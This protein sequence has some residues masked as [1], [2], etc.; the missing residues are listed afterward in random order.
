MSITHLV[1]THALAE[2]LDDPNWIVFDC[3]FLLT[4][5]D[6]R[7]A[8]YLQ[9]HIPGAVYAHLDRDLSAPIVPGVTGRH[10]LPAPEKAARRFGELG[11]GPGMQVV[12]YDDLGGSL[13]AVRLWW[14]LRWLGHTAV[15]VLDGG[16]QGWLAEGRPV[17]NGTETRPAQPFAARPQPGMLLTSDEVEQIRRDPAYRLVDVRLPERYRG[18]VEP[19]DPLAGHIPGALNLPYTNNLNAEGKFRTPQE[20]YDF[21]SAELGGVPAGRVVFYCGSG[22]TSIH[23]LLAL[24]IAGLGE[25]RLYAGSWSE[26]IASRQRPVA[27]GPEPG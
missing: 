19:I 15:A 17:R 21:Y 27:L 6:A 14:M 9:A 12:A 22:V 20:L 4:Q 3:R 16:W 13:A 24:Q 11:I 8:D 1:S 10:P 2:H 7:E 5:P 18:E 26:W 25:A 23:S